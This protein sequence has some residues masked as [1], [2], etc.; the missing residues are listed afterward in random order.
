M[1]VPAWA[2]LNTVAQA[3]PESVEQLARPSPTP[4]NATN[5]DVAG[6]Q[7]VS[8]IAR[9][10]CWHAGGDR[11]V[12]GAL[13]RE[14]L[15]PLELALLEGRIQV[16]DARAVAHLALVTLRSGRCPPAATGGTP[17]SREV[18]P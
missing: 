14:L 13:Q 6:P 12:I 9:V 18:P 16:A 8:S 5:R 7:A 10:L 1:P 17:L 11:A 15:V 4:P 3:S 2:W